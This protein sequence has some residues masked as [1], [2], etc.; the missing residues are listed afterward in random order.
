MN[1]KEILTEEDQKTKKLEEKKQQEEEKQKIVKEKKQKQAEDKIAKKQAEDK[2]AK[3][4]KQEKQN[5][6]N[7][8]EKK[9]ATA[10][11]IIEEF[12]KLQIPKKPKDPK[13]PEK[14]KDPKKPEK[15][16]DPKKPEKLKD[17]KKPK[18]ITSVNQI[19]KDDIKEIKDEK[20]LEKI[21]DFIVE[22]KQDIEKAL[23]GYKKN[24]K[25][26][27]SIIKGAM[28]HV[29]KAP[30]ILILS[31]A[32]FLGGIGY[33]I[34]GMK[35][36][37]L[38]HNYEKE[39]KKVKNNIANVILDNS[40]DITPN[41]IKKY[42]LE[43]L[44]ASLEKL[45]QKSKNSK[46]KSKEFKKISVS[47]FTESAK[48]L[49]LLILDMT[50]VIL[51]I[52][53]NIANMVGFDK[54]KNKLSKFK[55]K[56][57]SVFSK[58]KEIQKN[59]QEHE[60]PHKKE[61]ERNEKIAN[62]VDSSLTISSK[63]LEVLG[64]ISIVPEPN[65]YAITAGVTVGIVAGS[66]MAAIYNHT[67]EKL[68]KKTLK[69]YDKLNEAISE[70]T[71]KT[72]PQVQNLQSEEDKKAQKEKIQQEKQ[73][74]IKENA[75]KIPTKIINTFEIYKENLSKSSEILE[76]IEKNKKLIGDISAQQK[77]N[78]ELKIKTE[79]QK[80]RNDDK[81]NKEKLN[82][83]INKQFNKES[84]EIIQK[85]VKGFAEFSENLMKIQDLQKELDHELSKAYKI[86]GIE[87]PIDPRIFDKSISSLKEY[88]YNGFDPKKEF[89]IEENITDIQTSIE[90][91]QKIFFNEKLN[92]IKKLDEEF[93]KIENGKEFSEESYQNHINNITE[94]IEKDL[95]IEV[96]TEAVNILYDDLNKILNN[97]GYQ[98]NNYNQGIEALSHNHNAH[99]VNNTVTPPQ[100]TSHGTTQPQGH[101]SNTQQNTHSQPTVNS[102]NHNT[103][104]GNTTHT[105][106][107]V[108]TKGFLDYIKSG[109]NSITD[110]ILSF[111]LFPD[112]DGHKNHERHNN[113]NGHPTSSYLT[114]V[115]KKLNLVQEMKNDL[116]KDDQHNNEH[117]QNKSFQRSNSFSEGVKNNKIKEIINKH[118]EKGGVTKLTQYSQQQD[119]S[120]SF[121]EKIKEQK[122]N[123]SNRRNSIS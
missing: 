21:A 53:I 99:T 107:P 40:K 102:A 41:P 95:K 54:I 42:Q 115:S 100:T 34:A 94:K 113:K 73:D 58:K 117:P 121:V 50:T 20:F 77:S 68:A 9:Q 43:E 51:G 16:K 106:N 11:E 119:F 72:N 22:D 56:I 116:K 85:T 101:N 86:H 76:L 26:A 13:K 87:N 1:N 35:E 64:K 3:E 105:T 25:T 84:Q 24:K 70:Y 55:D 5:R 37:F 4:K 83:N 108:K 118:D 44:Q 19:T 91:G 90:N 60:D 96:K 52:V 98:Y 29:L 66:T 111:K 28:V 89:N 49:V 31:V 30:G 97:H 12:N 122:I 46:E 123:E 27:I 120:K 69:S 110:F 7:K 93:V 65:L 61:E 71:S 92:E 23:Q 63:L 36:K 33:S 10:N 2:I 80:N 82:D 47:Q 32:H 104:K 59:T 79:E 6:K 8:K 78:A 48:V 103:V 62:I 74:V 81:D 15:L 39:I 17:P 112:V 45:E 114:D 88:Q 109:L 67:Q 38:S 57:K 18:A 14:L 75:P